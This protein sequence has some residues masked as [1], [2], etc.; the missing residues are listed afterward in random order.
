VNLL[1]KVDILTLVLIL[2]ILSPAGGVLLHALTEGRRSLFRN[3]IVALAYYVALALAYL[4][5]LFLLLGGVWQLQFAVY[6]LLAL[7]P[8]I[9]LG[10]AVAPAVDRRR[11][12]SGKCRTCGYDLTCNVSGR[13]PECGT[14]ID[15]LKQ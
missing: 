1:P 6:T 12:I 5:T 4:S 13:C 7:G 8:V 15:W 11:K 9:G 10:I 3:V 14:P 2:L